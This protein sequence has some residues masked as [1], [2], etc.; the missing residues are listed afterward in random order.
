[1][2]F[3]Q[4]LYLIKSENDGQDQISKDWTSSFRRFLELLLT[5]LSGEQIKIN[6][7]FASELDTEAIYSPFTML[8][9]VVSQDLLN[10]SNFKDE[11]K[12]F[13]EKAINKGSNNI[14]WNSRIFK[15]LREPQK[16][17]FLLDYLSNSISYDFFHYDSST[18]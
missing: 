16:G 17:H 9:P 4:Y 10:S 14:T 2:S 18:E 3:G 15:V 1:M 6:E 7:V 5:R 8:I 11:L 12:L 13:H